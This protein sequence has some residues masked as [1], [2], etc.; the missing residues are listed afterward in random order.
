MAEG[1]Y[2]HPAYHTRSGLMVSKGLSRPMQPEVRPQLP[3]CKN[4]KGAPRQA[5]TAAAGTSVV[6]EQV[7]RNAGRLEDVIARR[8]E[9]PAQRRQIDIE[10]LPVP[11]AHLAG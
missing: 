3:Y 6:A 9:L 10:Q 11:L 8:L 7:L 5:P 1:F 4:C 2:R